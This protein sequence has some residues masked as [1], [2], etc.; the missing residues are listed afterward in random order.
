[1]PKSLHPSIIEAKNRMGNIYPWLFII[2][3]T[4]PTTPAVTWYFVAN[5]E[6][7]TFNGQEYTAMPFLVHLPSEEGSGKLATT[8]II[9]YD[10]EQTAAGYFESL[11]GGEG[12][13]VTLRLVNAEFL[14][15]SSYTADLERT[16]ALL[17]PEIDEDIV[18]LKLG[19]PNP[20]RDRYPEDKYTS[21]Y[22][23][24][25]KNFKGV[26]CKY[27]GAETTCDGRLTTCRT[28]SNVANFGGKPGLSKKTVRM[29]S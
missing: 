6:N 9:L 4:V 28:L 19:V 1:M 12:T 22:C 14:S 3:I 26:E 17:Y 27:V 29:V 24:W 18:S 2:D 15:S 10:V 11:D 7:I 21:V 16:Y 5:T 23:N 20:M 25:A 8:S 13:E